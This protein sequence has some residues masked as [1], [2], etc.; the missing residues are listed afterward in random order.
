MK[1]NER[2][3][4]NALFN[5]LHR[6][7]Y[8]YSLDQCREQ[9]FLPTWTLA[10]AISSSNDPEVNRKDH[11][12]LT[13]EFVD[14]LHGFLVQTSNRQCP[15]VLSI[16]FYS[17]STQNDV[18][19]LLL[20]IISKESEYQWKATTKARAM[21]LLGNMYED[22]GFLTMSEVAGQNIQLPDLLGLTNNPSLKKL[23]HDKRVFAIEAAIHTLLVLPS[24]DSYSFP[25]IMTQLVDVEAPGII[26]ERD[27]DDQGYNNNSIYES[28][29]QGK[30]GLEGI[31]WLKEKHYFFFFN[32]HALTLAF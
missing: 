13:E 22:A 16:F 5:P 7:P 24:S 32:I 19:K 15:P 6:L 28:W 9:Q 26:D 18:Q 20:M 8:A 4:V 23:V 12:A 25:N 29:V 17:R 27:R 21:D 2:L 3:L 10:N 11:I 31:P 14:A 30:R 1:Y